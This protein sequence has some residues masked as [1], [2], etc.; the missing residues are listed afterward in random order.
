ML[1]AH[2]FE[3]V[4]AVPEEGAAGYVVG[5]EADYPPG[6]NL[7]QVHDESTERAA[8]GMWRYVYNVIGFV[9]T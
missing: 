4:C 1:Q 3:D 8:V 2:E 6:Q 9:P 7:D 5:G